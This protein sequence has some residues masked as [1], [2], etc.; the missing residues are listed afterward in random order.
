MHALL[1]L[2]RVKGIQQSLAH[3][4]LPSRELV[5]LCRPVGSLQ[6]PLSLGVLIH[7]QQNSLQA[8]DQRGIQIFSD[9]DKMAWQ[10][11]SFSQDAYVRL[12][13]L[14]ESGIVVVAER[15]G[16]DLFGEHQ[17]DEFV[18]RVGKNVTD[19]P[20]GNIGLDSALLRKLKSQPRKEEL[21]K[22]MA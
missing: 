5:E 1:F 16:G 7:G 14:A 21:R 3:R 17:V 11:L 13:R 4:L 15:T 10:L 12:F 8:V 20:G 18:L 2:S 9:G 22:K 19:F 6:Y